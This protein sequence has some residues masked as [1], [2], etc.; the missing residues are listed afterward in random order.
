MN[1]YRSIDICITL[2]CG[3]KL[4]ADIDFVATLILEQE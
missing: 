4:F 1:G 3:L 2:Q